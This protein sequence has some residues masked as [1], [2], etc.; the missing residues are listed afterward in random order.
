[1][2]LIEL[3]KENLNRINHLRRVQRLIESDTFTHLWIEATS[4][5]REELTDQILLGNITH[6]E[7]WV[8]ESN[9]LDL[10]TMSLRQLRA[11]AVRLQIPYY[12]RKSKSD[13]IWEILNANATN[14]K[15]ASEETDRNQKRNGTVHS[16]VG[17]SESQNL[18]QIVPVGG[19]SERVEGSLRPI[20]TNSRGIISCSSTRIQGTP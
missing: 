5:K 2:N 6:L 4:E 15:S 18:Q 8:K 20:E 9:Q 1:M 14:E 16:E 13:L 11:E 10:E 17:E 7:L 12:C 3:Q 19:D